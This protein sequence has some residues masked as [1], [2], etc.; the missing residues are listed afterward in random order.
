MEGG[1]TAIGQDIMH[2]RRMTERKRRGGKEEKKEGRKEGR[3]AFSI[4]FFPSLNFYKLSPPSIF[5]LVYFGDSGRLY[6]LS[7]W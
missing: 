2:E 5:L 1:E 6:N 4:L 7:P 3:V